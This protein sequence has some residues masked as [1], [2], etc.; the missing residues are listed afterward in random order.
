MQIPTHFLRSLMVFH[1][2]CS[3][4]RLYFVQYLRQI[5]VATVLSSSLK[6]KVSH[7]TW[8]HRDNWNVL[9]KSAAI[10]QKTQFLHVFTMPIF[11]FGRYVSSPD[12]FL[13]TIFF[14]GRYFSSAALEDAIIYIVISISPRFS[15]RESVRL[16]LLYFQNSRFVTGNYVLYRNTMKIILCHKMS[17]RFCYN[18]LRVTLTGHWKLIQFKSKKDLLAVRGLLR[19]YTLA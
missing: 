5:N 2:I 16:P 10:L 15:V 8:K 9:R 19:V 13:R 17:G 3:Y 11:F 14:F 6:I 18:Y 4:K 1:L 12:M 7:L